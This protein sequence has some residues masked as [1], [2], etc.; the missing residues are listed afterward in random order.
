MLLRFLDQPDGITIC[1]SVLFFFK[2]TSIPSLKTTTETYAIRIP[3]GVAKDK[4]PDFPQHLT[5]KPL[6]TLTQLF[7]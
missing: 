6:H 4:V 2:Y 1:H 5:I 3:W 7:M